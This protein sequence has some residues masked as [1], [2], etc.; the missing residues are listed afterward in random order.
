MDKFYTKGGKGARWLNY[1]KVDQNFNT[2][3]TPSWR[4]ATISSMVLDSKLARILSNFC[5][6][7][8]KA[9]FVA[10]FITPPLSGEFSLGQGFLILIKGAV[11]V[12]L[13]LILSWHFAKMEDK[14]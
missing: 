2:I 1:L 5:A 10:T 4:L 9:Y 13:F 7:I 8:A 11:D 12:I 6:D 14:I 3:L